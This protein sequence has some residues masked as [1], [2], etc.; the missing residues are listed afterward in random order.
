MASLDDIRA[1]KREL[2]KLVR[3]AEKLANG[4][5]DA[6]LPGE[7]N[8]TRSRV[9]RKA[10]TREDQEI[11]PIPDCANPS[12]RAKAD[13]DL[14]YFIE[15]YFPL[16]VS[17]GWSED[18]LRVIAK[19]E[20]TVVNGEWFAVAMP[21]GSG[22]T[23]LSQFAVL[24]A[25]LTGR[26]KYVFFVGGTAAKA[27]KTL[28]NVKALLRHNDLLAAD[29]P[30]ALV[31]II[32]LEGQPRRCGGQRY[33]GELTHIMWGIDKLG[34]AMIPGAPCSG[35]VI[36]VSGIEGDIRG[37][38]YARPD[39]Y[40]VRPTLVF[41]DDP[42][43]DSS[44][45]SL[46]QTAN[47]YEI[48][49]STLAGLSGPDQNTAMMLTCTV[50]KPGDLA[51]QVLD[52]ATHPHWRG[53]RT[54]AV[55]SF[56]ANMELWDD[57]RR[58]RADEM[59]HEGDGSAARD[60]YLANRDAMDAGAK[61]SWESRKKPGDVSALQHMMHILF[62]RGKS[63]F[64]SELQNEPVPIEVEKPL[65]TAEE[66]AAKLSG[67][68]RKLVPHDATRATAFIDVHG[69]VLYW[70]VCAWA[71]GFTGYV[72]DYGT[73]PDQ[74]LPYFLL[75][76]A[77]IT[78][79]SVSGKPGFEA[80]L[81]A[82]LDVLAADILGRAWQVDGGGEVKVSKC[83]IDANWH[84]STNVV[85]QF[86]R[87]SGYSSIV[88]PSHG[89]GLRATRPS[90]ATWQ[91][92]PG[93]IVG[94]NWRIRRGDGRVVTHCSFDANYWKSFVFDRL[95]APAGSAGCLSI[96]GNDAKA[97]QLYAD[98]MTAEYTVRA[99]AIRVVDEWF[100][101]PDRFDNHW[102]DCTVGCAIGA[103]ILGA[104]V[105]GTGKFNEKKPKRNFAEMQAAAREN[106]RRS[107]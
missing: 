77:T 40:S 87:A 80:Q 28:N 57:Y 10:E 14:L 83:L 69:D 54:K 17:L 27:T 97:H 94:D 86:C 84:Q 29:Y 79:A 68:A 82:S 101:R 102:L 13:D 21:R 105:D 50:I 95:K 31:P 46:A 39:G 35:A 23:T 93:D 20:R 16:D 76:D 19:L 24:W 66:V 32:D 33:K 72:I 92:K 45:K 12:E 89:M 107:A 15:R 96:F 44:A 65:L 7:A 49:H 98:H 22:K 8:R 41:V 67:Y 4:R 99:S 70:V 104:T 85:H 75:R 43:T 71:D 42:Q 18:H 9:Q 62:D 51:E 103:S 48:L 61:L 81:L 63:A 37:A 64:Q 34:F 52:R 60:F 91:K 106:A 55:L 36:H 6:P 25:I 59:Q 73:F 58:I 56:P 30:E 26:H 1:K 38:N 53:E 2:D 5:E 90:M 11:P 100:T 3:N 47:R 78:M 88:T 74:R